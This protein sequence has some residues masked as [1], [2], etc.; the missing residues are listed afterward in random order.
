[1]DYDKDIAKSISEAHAQQEY[2][3]VAVAIVRDV[4]N[5]VLFVRSAKNLNE[6]YLPQGGIEI[7][8]SASGALLRELQEELRIPSSAVR[9]LDYL[10]SSD[11]DAESNRVDKRGFSK[12]K[13]YYFFTLSYSNPG[14][15]LR[16]NEEEIAEYRWVGL[17]QVEII[18][19]STRV[20]KRLL[21]LK[22]LNKL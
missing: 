7:Q 16:I 2:R 8:E 5:G 15:T 20:E 9:L 19:S 14:N 12:G 4:S 1:M 6:W 10:G 13:R 3:P 11:L 21:I 17:G 18:L 22:Y